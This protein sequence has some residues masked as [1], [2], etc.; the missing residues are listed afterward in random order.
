MKIIL[1]LVAFFLFGFALF[2]SAFADK[3]DANI[4]LTHI[5]KEIQK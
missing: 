1:A 5:S 3:N 4:K 2:S